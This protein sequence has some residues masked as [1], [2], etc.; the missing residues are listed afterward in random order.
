M[1]YIGILLIVVSIVTLASESFAQTFGIKAGLNLSNQLMKDDNT[2]YS[3]D[4]KMNPGFHIGATAEFLITKI[5]SFETRLLIS[6]KGYKFS[7]EEILLG[8]ILEYKI[9]CNLYYVD[10]PLD[11]KASLAVEGAKIYGALGPYLGIGLFGKRKSELTAMGE[12]ETYEEDIEWGSDEENYEIKRLDFGLTIGAGFEISS[13]Q[14]GL[15]YCL[16]LANI[17]AY[18]D[19]GIKNKNRV[20]GISVGYKFGKK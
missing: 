20:L 6:T 4:F 18:T 2:T 1:K 11:V 10:V 13:I 8:E 3:D 12:T 7:E 5:F 14:I 16:G 9:K 15:S 17:S 19:G